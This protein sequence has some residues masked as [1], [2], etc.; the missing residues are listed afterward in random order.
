M[1]G[2]GYLFIQLFLR[3]LGILG[4]RIR[5]YGR[6]N[7]PEKGGV[8]IASNHQSYADPVI[9]GTGS[10]RPL[11]YLA[12]ETLFRFAPFAALIRAFGAIEIKRGAADRTAM[13][14]VVELLNA[15]NAVVMFPEGTRTRDGKIGPVKAGALVIARRAN[16]PVVPA[17]IRGAFE[18]WPRKRPL[19]R[20]HEIKVAFGKPMYPRDFKNSKSAF[21][22]E[23][24]KE[25]KNLLEFLSQKK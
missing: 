19:P 10:D 16:A 21:T 24:E 4:A 15:G 14:R 5:V 9:L 18:A 20:L 12:R 6:E 13:N 23:L 22:R 3:A 2:I 11:K 25:L 1:K 8:I 7:I 17:V